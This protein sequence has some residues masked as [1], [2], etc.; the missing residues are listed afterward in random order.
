MLDLKVLAIL[1]QG[2]VVIFVQ[3]EISKLRIKNWDVYHYSDDLIRERRIRRLTIKQ[4]QF[5]ANRKLFQLHLELLRQVRI[6]LMQQVQSRV[7]KK[8][9]GCA[10]FRSCF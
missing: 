3:F 5:S 4:V 1:H 2:N 10:I 7:G 6:L 8:C 9:S